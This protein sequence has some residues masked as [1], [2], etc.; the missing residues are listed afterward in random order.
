MAR[1]NHDLISSSDDPTSS[2]GGDDGT[3]GNAATSSWR[4]RRRFRPDL[5]GLAMHVNALQRLFALLVALAAF[6]AARS[7]LAIESWQVEAGYQQLLDALGPNVP[8]GAGVAVSQVEAPEGTAANPPYFPDVMNPEFAAASDPLMQQVQIVD[9]SGAA[10]NGIS[11]HATFVAYYILGNNFGIAKAANSLITYD[12]N[13]WLNDVLHVNGNTAPELQPYKVQNHSWIGS[14]QSNSSDIAA[15]QRFD[16][17]IETGDMTAVVGANNYNNASPTTSPPQHPQ[18]LVHSYNAIVAG[19][20]DSRHSRGVTTTLYGPGRFRPDIVSAAPSTSLAT[21]QI[22]SVATVL[23]GV[24]AGTDADRSE[25]MKAI[26][27]AGATKTE[28]ANFVDPA[29][30]A[31]NPW[32]HT[33]TR[34]LDDLFGAGE[35]NVYNSYLMTVGGHNAG[36]TAPPASSVSSY[37]WDYQ[38]RKSDSAVGDI[39]YNFTV[40]QGSTA[41]ELSIMLAWNAK[42]TDTEPSSAFAPIQSLQNLD[43]SFYDSTASFMGT[44]LDQSASTVDNVEHIYRTN[45]GPGTYT[46]KVT[47]AA[48]WDY[49][50]AWRMSTLFNAPNADFDEDG[51]VTGSDFIL[52]QRNLGTLVG[53]SHSQGDADGDGDVDRVDLSIYTAAS[54]TSPLPGG[55]GNAASGGSS[56]AHGIHAVVSIPEPA[57]WISAAAAL[58]CGAALNR[59]RLC[60]ILRHRDVR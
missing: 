8:L 36:S 30:N 11:N 29:T 4:P 7:A 59:R 50:L 58:S 26:L 41:K 24:V 10:S 22:S 17:L 3:V 5:T 45:V 31:P 42:V 16:Y 47:G 38:N 14:L 49:G 2:A 28:F 9:G 37:G 60:R 39:F 23:R 44:L 40:P 20:S 43:L 13:R 18:L 48:N 21:A 53:A 33:T 1:H 35:V 12:A 6:G 19:R 52:W 32:D 51:F 25:T 15:L 54:L 56:S 57:T 46:L 55:S 34:P 27:L